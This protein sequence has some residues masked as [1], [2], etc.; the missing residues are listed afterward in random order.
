[1]VK[2]R[3]S[4]CSGGEIRN[5]HANKPSDGTAVLEQQRA[6]RV[7]ARKEPLARGMRNTDCRVRVHGACGA[8]WMKTWKVAV[9]TFTGSHSTCMR[10]SGFPL[11][12]AGTAVL[13]RDH[14]ETAEDAALPRTD[15]LTCFSDL[16][17]KGQG[18]KLLNIIIFAICRQS[19]P[20]SNSEIN[21]TGRNDLA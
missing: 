1:M 17:P 21:N 15:P 13:R 11:H 16:D 7:H 20:L 10:C 2:V 14:P 18:S 4:N 9:W 19:V 3:V 5:L 12:P 8:L 6:H